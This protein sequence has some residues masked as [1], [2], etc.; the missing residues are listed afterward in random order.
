MPM[1]VQ[2]IFSNPEV[3]EPVKYMISESFMAL[4]LYVRKRKEQSVEGWKTLIIY[5]NKNQVTYLSSSPY[6]I[7]TFLISKL[8]TVQSPQLLLK[9]INLQNVTF[10]LNHYLSKNGFQLQITVTS[11]FDM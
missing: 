5:I 3:W 11:K 10:L 6:L 7:N 2:L 4:M 1:S 9:Q 8:L